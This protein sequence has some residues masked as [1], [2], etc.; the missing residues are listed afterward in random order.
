MEYWSLFNC[1][2]QQGESNLIPKLLYYNKN[3]WQW[4]MSQN[5]T[6]C[7]FSTFMMV[8][9]VSQSI[10]I[11]VQMLQILE[12]CWKISISNL[13]LFHSIFFGKLLI[14]YR[15]H[16]AWLDVPYFICVAIMGFF[17]RTYL[18]FYTQYLK[19]GKPSS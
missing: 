6:L 10:V 4:N 9:N 12:N 14:C 1:D 2:L 16:I 11:L 13:N 5:D 7:N 15:G 18:S 3:L 8:M 17:S 19:F